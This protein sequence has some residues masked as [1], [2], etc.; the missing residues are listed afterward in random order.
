MEQLTNLLSN[1]AFIKLEEDLAFI[2]NVLKD[3]KNKEKVER[4]A[5]GKETLMDAMNSVKKL[6]KSDLIEREWLPESK[7]RCSVRHFYS[8]FYLIKEVV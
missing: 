1:A 2:E 7:E 6:K 4:V 5:G 8:L 3:E